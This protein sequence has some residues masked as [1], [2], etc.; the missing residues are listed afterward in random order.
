MPAAAPEKN[1]DAFK[2]KLPGT[3]IRR[4]RGPA[5]SPISRRH[6]TGYVDDETLASYRAAAEVRFPQPVGDFGLVLLEAM[7]KGLP[8]AS[9]PVTGPPDVIVAAVAPAS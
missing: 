9:Y 5:A 2:L 6:Y 1:I 7:A 3:E 8:V 4:R